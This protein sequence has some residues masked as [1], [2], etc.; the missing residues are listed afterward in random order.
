M[1]LVST[2]NKAT[3][4][5]FDKTKSKSPLMDVPSK[6]VLSVVPAFRLATAKEPRWHAPE[7]EKRS[8]PAAPASREPFL[9]SRSGLGGSLGPRGAFSA[10]VAFA[11]DETR[12]ATRG[13][14]FLGATVT[15]LAGRAALPI[16]DAI[17]PPAKFGVW[18]PGP[19]A[20]RPFRVRHNPANSELRSAFER[21]DVPVNIVHGTKGR[22]GWKVPLEQLDV[23]F[24]LPLF[25]SGLRVRLR[26]ASARSRLSPYD[27]VR[28]LQ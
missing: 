11:A 18:G 21:G 22:L 2:K 8:P 16:G 4:S 27:R 15:Q 1:S 23:A 26:L 19:A 14:G 28:A 5:P 3:G 20:A 13:G 10:A 7:E 12:P 24:Y 25:A 9:R 6:P 17:H